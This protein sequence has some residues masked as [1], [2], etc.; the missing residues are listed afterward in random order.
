MND[1]FIRGEFRNLL[2]ISGIAF[3]KN[4]EQ[5]GAVKYFF[6]RLYHKCLSGS[7]IHC[8]LIMMELYDGKTKYTQNKNTREKT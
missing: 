7:Y 8:C 1:S 5:H 3:C 2:N 4:S 6:K